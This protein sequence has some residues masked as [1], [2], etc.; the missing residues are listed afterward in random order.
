L[1]ISYFLDYLNAGGENWYYYPYTGVNLQLPNTLADGQNSTISQN[2]HN[3][4]H[5]QT[6]ND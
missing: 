3:I 4:D 5:Y 6:G 1:I 2:L